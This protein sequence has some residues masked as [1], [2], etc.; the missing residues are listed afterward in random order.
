[1]K[2]DKDS[3]EI[4]GGPYLPK[5]YPKMWVGL[6]FTIIAILAGIMWWEAPPPS[7]V[8]HF[9]NGSTEL[10][11]VL[12]DGTLGTEFQND[13]SPTP[14]VTTETS[15]TLDNFTNVVSQDIEYFIN[16]SHDDLPHTGEMIVFADN[17]PP[18]TVSKVDWKTDGT[19]IDVTLPGIINVPIKIWIVNSDN[20]NGLTYSVIKDQAVAAVVRANQIYLNE[21]QGIV[22]TPDSVVDNY[23]D[24]TNDSNASQFS[25]FTCLTMANNIKT[26]IGHQSGMLNVYYVAQADKEGLSGSY[27]PYYGTFCNDVIAV[28]IKAGDDLLVHELGHAFSLGHVGDPFYASAFDQLNVMHESSTWRAYLTEGQTYRQVT[29]SPESALNNPA[30]YSFTP[31]ITPPGSPLRNCRH[32]LSRE[33]RVDIGGIHNLSQWVQQSEKSDCPVVE[34]RIWADGA[35][36]PP[37]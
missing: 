21:K 30:I 15:I 31:P 19:T 29:N 22:L 17:R 1:M 20:P 2:K 9:M 27:S 34:K 18:L 33:V 12:I 4:G 5:T 7:D 25:R 24:K 26:L 13:R 6:I 14:S 28:G 16:Q 11:A 36:W 3:I 23:K 10:K 35:G 37:N 32:F 8:I